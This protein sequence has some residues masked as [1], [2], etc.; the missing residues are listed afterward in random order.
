L[1]D[2]FFHLGGDSLHCIKL[3]AQ[4][5]K[6]Q[7]ILSIEDIGVNRTLQ[8]MSTCA[9]FG[10]CAQP[11][12]RGDEYAA[13][14]IET[15]APE[16]LR[17]N[18]E[19]VA[20]A[21]DFQAWCI[22]QG[23]LKSH[24]WH[25][26][27][28]LKFPKA[29]DVGRL[30]RACQQLINQHALLRTVFVVKARQTFQVVLKAEAFPFRFTVEQSSDSQNMDGLVK[31]IIQQDMKRHR[32]LGDTLVAFTLVQDATAS[33]AQLVLRISHAQYDALSMNN[34]W[35]S[36]EA[37]YFD[38]PLEVVPFTDFCAEAALGSKN[39]EIFWKEALANSSMSEVRSHTRPSVNCP[40]NGAVKISIPLVD[41]KA[42]G[43]TSATAVLTS[44]SIV[45]SKLTGQDSVVFGYLTSGRHM[46]MPNVSDVI[47]ACIN[48]IPLRTDIVPTA[49]ASSL[50]D[51]TQSNYLKSLQHGHI[52]HQNIIEKCTNW[53]RWT[54]FSTV[55]NHLS[56]GSI[57]Q[58]F[59][60]LGGCAGDVYEPEHDKADL[61]L[62]THAPDNKLEVELRY[63]K[64]AFSE[65]QVKAVLNCFVQTYEQLPHLL[66]QKL[67]E[68]LA[69]LDV[70]AFQHSLTSPKQARRQV[71]MPGTEDTK[72]LEEL[73]CSAWESVLGSDFRSSPGFT[74]QTPFYEIWG[75]SIAAAALAFEYSKRGFAMSSEELLDFPSVEETIAL[76]STRTKGDVEKAT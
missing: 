49:K 52:G 76:L 43:Y 3:I 70:A 1:Q 53:P 16:V 41:L 59:P 22:G 73:V 60:E 72:I 34:L 55:V 14:T 13:Y 6:E 50:L 31:N 2:D 44:W 67:S 75:N 26:Y 57:E 21:T 23:L 39:S 30:Q 15:V 74:Y 33:T 38:R 68:I 71:P 11:S 69:R 63:S 62:Q 48:V 36:L 64:Q 46:M 4:A 58:P 40:I 32:Q 7:V 51:S 65:D 20:L 8:A 29:P 19:A 12:T 66:E 28:I 42:S 45:L 17:D 9:S 54:R 5:R 25:D 27:L 10:V 56:F 18:V 47:G 35:R 24:G 37:L 61:W